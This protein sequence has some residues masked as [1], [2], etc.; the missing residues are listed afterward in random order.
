MDDVAP[1]EGRKHSEGP[2]PERKSARISADLALFSLLVIPVA[3]FH[4]LLFRT[5]LAL[6][7]LD[8]YDA[9]LAFANAFARDHG[10]RSRLIEI[11]AWQHNEYKLIFEQAVVALM[12]AVTGCVN[13][14]ELL[15]LGNAFV[16]LIGCV[17]WLYFRTDQ[18]V[19]RKHLVAFVP[20]VFLLFNLQY[21][22]T[23]NWAAGSL[24][25]LPVLA[26][27]LLALWLAAR[28]GRSACLLSCLCLMLAIASSG[29]GFFVPVAALPV[30]IRRRAWGQMSVWGALTLGMVALYVFHYRLAPTADVDSGRRQTA[31]SPAIPRRRARGRPRCPSV[32]PLPVGHLPT[33]A[34]AWIWA[35]AAGLFCGDALPRHYRAGRG[36]DAWRNRNLCRDSIALSHLLLP[37]PHLHVSV[38]LGPVLPERSLACA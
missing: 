4:Y 35:S 24:Q 25:N 19:S 30:L 6:P 36:R 8:D 38:R 5:Q 37:I 26:F 9:V 2:V 1:M 23:V 28:P 22:E 18:A 16:L 29:N 11:V 15:L 33:C 32:G 21:A 14:I 10:I 20:V 27:G 34:M 31:L 17:L 13:F 12:Y 7:I 3:V